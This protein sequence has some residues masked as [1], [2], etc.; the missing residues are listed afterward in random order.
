M[1]RHRETFRERIDRLRQIGSDHDT[2]DLSAKDQDA[3]RA[4][5]ANRD[6]LLAALKAIQSQCAGHADEFSQRVWLIAAAA[7]ANAEAHE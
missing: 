2:W 4:V 5:L 6:E 7:I 3:V 1:N